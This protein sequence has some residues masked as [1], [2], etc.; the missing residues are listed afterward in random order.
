MNPF[1]VVDRNVQSQADI[2]RMFEN[3]FE[4]LSVSVNSRAPTSG[5]LSA[6]TNVSDMMIIPEEDEDIDL[7][8]LPELPTIPTSSEPSR[9]YKAW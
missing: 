3:N 5:A 8:G 6:I 1:K 7:P 9:I 2:D 4:N